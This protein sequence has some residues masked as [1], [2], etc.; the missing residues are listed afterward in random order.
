MAAALW[1]QCRYRNQ[2]VFNEDNVWSP[3][4]VVHNVQGTIQDLI[5]CDVSVFPDD[6]RAGFGCALRDDSGD[7]CG[8]KSV[9]C[10]TDC[11]YAFLLAQN[12]NDLGDVM[13]SNLV[14]KIRELC[15]REWSVH[16]SLILREANGI[17]DALAKKGA[18]N[19]SLYVE[20]L[21]PW[22]ELKEAVFLES[23][24]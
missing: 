21:C 4:K 5:N 1:W 10:E 9:I 11:R 15:N 18:L 22:M 23:G 2:Q 6:Q 12:T 20:W 24:N 7:W 14:A 16:W 17:A 13:D 8:I 3:L 19:G